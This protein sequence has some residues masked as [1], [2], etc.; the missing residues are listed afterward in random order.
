M[1]SEDSN[2]DKQRGCC[3]LSQVSLYLAIFIPSSLTDYK[4][5]V[6]EHRV[7]QQYTASV[8][9]LNRNFSADLASH[10]NPVFKEE[11]KRVQYLVSWDHKFFRYCGACWQS[12]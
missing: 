9:I 1:S 8:S 10:N 7:E 2:H 11:A 6:L 12:D 5:W 4:V 3:L